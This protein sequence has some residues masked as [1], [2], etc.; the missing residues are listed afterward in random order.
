MVINDNNS[1]KN[2]YGTYF[3]ND[4]SGWENIVEYKLKLNQ[5]YDRIQEL[6]QVKAI[7][8]SKKE[9]EMS[10]FTNKMNYQNAI[11]TEETIIVNGIYRPITVLWDTGSNHTLISK[12]YIEDAGLNPNMRSKIAT[13]NGE[14]NSEIYQVS[15]KIKEIGHIFEMAIQ[16]IPNIHKYGIDMLIG[17]DIISQGDFSLTHKNGELYFS[18]KYPSEG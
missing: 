15:I 7:P 8:I 14:V 18:F 9:N 5:N 12:E 6:F 11:V 3:F 17:M 16:A 2:H 4:D 13:V 10:V 1:H